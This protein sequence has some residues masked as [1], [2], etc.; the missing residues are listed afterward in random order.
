MQLLLTFLA[1]IPSA[2]AQC[3]L[4]GRVIDGA[5]GAPI[6]KVRV[7]AA[8]GVTPAILT[9]TDENGA[10]CFENL[11]L[12]AYSLVAQ[13]TGYLDVAYGSSRY[14]P[15]LPSIKVTH[16]RAPDA[17]TIEMTRRPVLAGRVVDA[18]GDA[19]G[20]A[21]IHAV[22]ASGAATLAR[23][24]GTITRTDVQ[25]RFRFYDL[26]PGTYHLI[27]SPRG[28]PSTFSGVYLGSHGEPLP[29]RQVETYY[30]DALT[31]AEAAAIELN[32]ASEVMGV[33]IRIQTTALRHVSGRVIG[34]FRGYMMLDVKLSTGGSEGA[35][36]QV[37]KDGSFRRDGLRPVKYTLRLPGGGERV[38]DLTNGDV[39][40]LLIEVGNPGR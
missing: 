17:V 15:G 11:D 18:G 37:G 12:G 32:A 26:D 2:L 7:Y 3:A 6:P 39:E 38:V 4:A 21:E 10:F 1:V 30:P 20:S 16:G 35:A 34:T 9:G 24:P 31:A 33:T 8:A 25:G 19:V 29:S 28:G 22:D 36:I 13:R 40:D 5:N 23:D 27:A 14:M